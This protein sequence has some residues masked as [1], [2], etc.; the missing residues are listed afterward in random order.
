MNRQLG[1]ILEALGKASLNFRFVVRNALMNIFFNY[2][3]ITYFGIIGAAYGTLATYALS[4][5]YNQF[6]L[7]QAL[8]VRFGSILHHITDGYARIFALGLQHLK[9]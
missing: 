7:H 6:Y 3:F 8:Q 9:K 1:V 5:L 2:L 4:T